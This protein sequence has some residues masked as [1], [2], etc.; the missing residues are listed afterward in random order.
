MVR[1]YVRNQDKEDAHYWSTQVRY[2]SQR[3]QAL[4]ICSF[5]GLTKIDPRL[6][7]G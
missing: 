1:A 5:E 6:C 4:H 7:R 3:L 2:V